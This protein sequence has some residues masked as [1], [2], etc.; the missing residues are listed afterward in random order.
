MATNSTYTDQ[1]LVKCKLWFVLERVAY[2]LPEADPK[3]KAADALA[4][5]KKGDSVRGDGVLIRGVQ[6]LQCEHEGQK[7][8]M[9]ID[10]AAV[11]ANRKFL[12]GIVDPTLSTPAAWGE[13]SLKMTKHWVVAEPIVYVMPKPDPKQKPKE[14]LETKKK[15]DIML[16][17]GMVIDGWQWLR[18]SFNGQLAFCL[19]DGKAVGVDR[20][21]LD[22]IPG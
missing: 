8:Y 19:I 10:G 22:P 5:L 1:E 16:G 7:G 12:E 2:L 13:T 6:W 9:L 18:T 21:F 20:K 17:D 15:D 3:Q 14:K 11:G 4:T